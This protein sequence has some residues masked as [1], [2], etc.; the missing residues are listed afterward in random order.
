MVR[1][2]PRYNRHIAREKLETGRVLQTSA[3]MEWTADH[4]G[5]PPLAGCP[6]RGAGGPVRRRGLRQALRFDN[7]N[8][9]RPDSWVILWA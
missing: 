5:P 1:D 6:P 9:T 8:L 4:R 7:C 2:G 3:Q